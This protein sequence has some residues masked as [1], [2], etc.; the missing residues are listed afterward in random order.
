MK[1]MNHGSATYDERVTGLV[2]GSTQES[3]LNILISSSSE[4][5]KTLMVLC[6][7]YPASHYA[8]DV[9]GLLDAVYQQTKTINVTQKVRTACED[10][11]KTQQN[12]TDQLILPEQLA[13]IWITAWMETAGKTDDASLWSVTSLPIADGATTANLEVDFSGIKVTTVQVDI[14]PITTV[15][16]TLAASTISATGST[17]TATQTSVTSVKII[18]TS[19]ATIPFTDF[20]N[21]YAWYN[22]YGWVAWMVAVIVMGII[23]WIIARLL[24][25]HYHI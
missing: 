5:E 24:S 9:S 10:Y 18:A 13:P 20:S 11:I 6:E 12:A 7:K 14:K 21:P 2:L 16:T 4:D 1:L 22:Q 8:Q 19:A 23:V 3:G 25:R 17:T 15:P